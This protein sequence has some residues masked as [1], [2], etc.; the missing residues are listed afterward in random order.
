MEN[1]EK[2][3]GCASGCAG[4]S[5]CGHDHAEHSMPEGASP[6]I[7]LTDDEGKDAWWIQ[8]P[9]SANGKGHTSLLLKEKSGYW[10]RRR[11]L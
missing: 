1:D 11:N 7:T 9:N 6:I 10:C 4:C 3:D 2:L 8:S 5:G